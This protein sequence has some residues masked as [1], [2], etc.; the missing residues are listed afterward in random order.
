MHEANVRRTLLLLSQ[1]EFLQTKMEAYE[2]VL[3]TRTGRALAFF[4]WCSFRR[5][6]DN[7]QLELLAKRKESFQKAAMMPKI[8]AVSG[9]GAHG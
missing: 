8:V 4:N 7:R 2:Y 9:N 6:V 1:F 5:V 3:S